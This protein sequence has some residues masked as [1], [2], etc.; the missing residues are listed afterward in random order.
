MGSSETGG[1]APCTHPWTAAEGGLRGQQGPAPGTRSFRRGCGRGW[2]HC[3]SAARSEGAGKGQRPGRKAADGRTLERSSDTFTL[4]AHTRENLNEVV[5]SR[6]VKITNG[7]FQSR[8][9]SF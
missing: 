1:A 6:S 4:C 2:A 9:R 3:R 5:S 8:S 7:F